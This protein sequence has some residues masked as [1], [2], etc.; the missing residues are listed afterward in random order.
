M[1]R[2]SKNFAPAS[3]LKWEDKIVQIWFHHSKN[4]KLSENERDLYFWL[5]VNRNSIMKVHTH[6][7]YIWTL[8]FYK[9]DTE[10][11]TPNNKTIWFRP[12]IDIITS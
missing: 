4:E 1:K 6:S 12:G 10:T 8:M 7:R 11:K 5:A 3:I 2:N 9:N